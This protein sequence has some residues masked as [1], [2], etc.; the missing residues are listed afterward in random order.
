M[1]LNE[2]EFISAVELDNEKTVFE[3]IYSNAKELVEKQRQYFETLW[4]N[5]TPITQRIKEIEEGAE[6]IHTEVILDSLQAILKGE[7]MDKNA[8]KEVSVFVPT[9]NA[10]KRI[11]NR[12]TLDHY[13]KLSKQ[14]ILVRLLIA[15]SNK[16]NDNDEVISELRGTKSNYSLQASSS[17]P[18]P[19]PNLQVRTLEESKHSRLRITLV[20]RKEVMMWEIKMILKQ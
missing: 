18:S 19:W 2:C 16:D 15:T 7:A 10:L 8:K 20:D 17:P 11:I 9:P 3:A 12:G 5:A 13:K 6:P 4:N 14:G 1:G